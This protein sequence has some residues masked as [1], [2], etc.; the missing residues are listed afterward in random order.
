MIIKFFQEFIK[1][2]QDNQE[3]PINYNIESNIQ[4]ILYDIIDN[5]DNYSIDEVNIKINDIINLEL[6]NTTNIIILELFVY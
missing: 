5:M 6:D 3:I 1:T 4:M 2:F